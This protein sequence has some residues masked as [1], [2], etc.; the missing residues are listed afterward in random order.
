MTLPASFCSNLDWLCFRPGAFTVRSWDV[1]LPLFYNDL[2]K[3]NHLFLG[4][5]V[6]YFL[7]LSPHYVGPCSLVASS[8][9]IRSKLFGLYASQK[10]FY[11]TYILFLFFQFILFLA[12]LGLCC[13]ARAFSSGGGRRLFLIAARGLLVVAASLVAEHSR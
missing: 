8:G 6:C 2:L 3:C 11:S 5:T 4:F 7:S 1:F 10:S 12:A 13:F 9:R